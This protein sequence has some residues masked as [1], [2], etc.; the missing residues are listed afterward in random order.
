MLTSFKPLMSIAIISLNL[1][2]DLSHI[3]S[4]GPGLY[5][6]IRFTLPVAKSTVSL[7]AS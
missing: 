6:P 1:G 7:S 3:F 5:V 4:S 2:F